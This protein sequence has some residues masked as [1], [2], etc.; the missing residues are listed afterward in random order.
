MIKITFEGDEDFIR[1]NADLD[2]LIDK[3]KQQE[4]PKAIF[5]LANAF[6]FKEL[7]RKIDDGKTEFVVTQEG[8]DKNLK[9]LY[10]HDIAEICMMAA[11]CND[12][13]ESRQAEGN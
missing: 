5:S 11:T 9:V 8:L 2:N 4:G 6:A 12:A 7:K 1:E 10:D 3:I 13:A